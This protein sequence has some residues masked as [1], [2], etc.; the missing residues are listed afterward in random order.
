MKGPTGS[1]EVPPSSPQEE[2]KSQGS[3]GA[4]RPLQPEE[5]QRAQQ[6]VHRFFRYA[7]LGYFA[8][9]AVIPVILAWQGV[10]WQGLREM[11]YLALWL[12]VVLPFVLLAIGLY[13]LVAAVRRR[14]GPGS[15][16]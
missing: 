8:L 7:G 5:L 1:P 10:L 15:G 13:R 3:T 16:P 6:R 2:D 12:L 11:A 9:L 4:D 14:G